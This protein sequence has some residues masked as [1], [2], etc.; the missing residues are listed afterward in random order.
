MH[1]RTIA[2]LYVIIDPE[3]C[4]GR[5]PEVIAKARSRAARA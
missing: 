1:N 2:G 4:R 3:A 5:A